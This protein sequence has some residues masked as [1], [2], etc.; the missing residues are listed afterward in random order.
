MS[1]NIYIT[2]YSS[3]NYRMRKKK[4]KGSRIRRYPQAND[5]GHNPS[6]A[7]SLPLLCLSIKLPSLYVLA[8]LITLVH[9]HHN[10]QHEGSLHNSEKLIASEC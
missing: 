7:A 6:E 5:E 4:I 1:S 8:G 2:I 3:P 9:S 10:R